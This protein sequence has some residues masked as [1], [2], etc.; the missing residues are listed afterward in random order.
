M[1]KPKAGGGW[2]AILYSLKKA[3]EA[4]GLLAMWRALR[5]KNTCKTCAL[6]MGGQKGGMVNEYG[7]FPEVCKKS[8]QAQAQDMMGAIDDKLWSQYSIAQLAERSGHDLEKLGRLNKPL[9]AGPNDEHYKIIEWDVALHRISEKLKVTEPDK[10]FFYFSGRSSN[11]A[12]FLTQLFARLYGTNNVNNCS[13]FCHQA[14]GVGL[15]SVFGSG[16]ATVQLEDVE[17]SDLIFV[18]G[19]N[20]ASNHPRFMRTLMNIRRGGGTVVVVNPLRERGLERFSVPS[21]TRSLL[22][23]SK[24]ADHYIQPHIGGD[25]AFLQG[26][27]KYVIENNAVDENF[28]DNFCDDWQ[29]FK[30]QAEDLSWQDICDNCGLERSEIEIIA[31]LYVKSKATV[32]AWAMGITHQKNGADAVRMISNLAMMR[33]MVGREQAGLLPLR[34]HSN[35]QGMGTMGVTPQLKKAVF[36]NLEKRLGSTLPST[37]GM[38]TL[39]CIEAAERGEVDFAWLLGGNLYES[40]PDLSSAKKAIENIGLVC[41]LNTTLNKGHVA[42][43]GRET[44]I[45]PVLARDEEIQPTTQE[46]MFSFVRMSSGGSKRMSGPLS[47]VQICAHVARSVLGDDGVIPW[48]K[49]LEHSSIRS[50]IAEVIP[51]FSPIAELDKNKEEFYIEGR[52]LDKNK[53]PTDSGKAKFFAI[54]LP[55]RNEQILRMMTVRSEGQYNSIVYDEY[56]RYRGQDRRDIIML[57]KSDIE[58]MGLKVDQKVT[59]SND[60]GTIKNYLVREAEIKAGNAVMYYPEGNVLT[61]RDRDPD[62]KTP[63]FKNIPISISA[64]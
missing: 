25:V 32:F 2:H 59:I 13:Y 57:A 56:D 55:E 18:I 5:A 14:S 29:V 51:G 52:R 19:A 33:G 15:T 28:V 58:K 49:M 37:K 38:D 24:I 31:E 27:A 9:Y 53:F 22:F 54:A 43:R 4:G 60:T 44:L 48:V 20:P 12:G 26:I 63:A 47:E 34:G 61:P 40:N 42:A 62:S 64:E 11:E 3:K 46:S 23:G 30:K 10:S 8:F 50:L 36:E 41:H 7:A 45:L 39:E 6:G 16:T 17:H 35:I 1:K 21:D